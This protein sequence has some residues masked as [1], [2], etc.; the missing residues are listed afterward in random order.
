MR[1]LFLHPRDPARGTQ[2]LILPLAPLVQLG[3]AYGVATQVQK[4]LGTLAEALAGKV[5]RAVRDARA[6]CKQLPTRR[7]GM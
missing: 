4:H 2:Q 5:T 1:L 7:F 6:V 3:R